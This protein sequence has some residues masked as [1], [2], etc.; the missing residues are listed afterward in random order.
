MRLPCA[1]PGD[2]IDIV[3][4]ASACGRDALEAGVAVL[5]EWGFRPRVPP[6]LF[7][8]SEIVAAPDATR[9]RV[10]DRALRR[11]DSAVVWCVRGGYGSQRLLP[12]LARRAAPSR[13][14]LLVGF[15]DVTALNVFVN[16][17]WGW[18]ALHAATV[19]GLGGGRLSKTALD[20]LRRV[21]A[22]HTRRLSFRLR[23][24]N[25]AAGRPRTVSAP[26]VGGNLK[27]LQSL[28]G[29]PFGVR[30]AGCILLLEDT[31]E[32]GYAID[33]ML[34]QLSQAGLLR[35]VRGIVF[36]QFTG[37][38][39]A[40]GRFTGNDVIAR[41]AERMRMPVLGDAPFGHAASARAVPLGVPVRLELGPERARLDVAWTPDA[42][43]G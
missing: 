35:G 14:K 37:G 13:R 2:A 21:V 39:E 22:G 30:P 16:Q 43:T 36:G 42:T 28:V 33:R 1:R 10:L 20:E 27:T 38:R 19:S 11:A 3:A 18:P 9:F 40:D 6:D 17:H 32:R 26:L 34:V 29:T 7:E 25:A 23:P 4:P 15:S 5:E 12:R 31:G 8:Q 24:L 41:F